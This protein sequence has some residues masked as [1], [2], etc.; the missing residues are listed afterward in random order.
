MSVVWDPLWL[1]SLGGVQPIE[2][3]NG[4][5]Q[6]AAIAKDQITFRKSINFSPKSD[7]GEFVSVQPW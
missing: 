1:A 4:S 6:I 5:R 2:P 3:A 7:E